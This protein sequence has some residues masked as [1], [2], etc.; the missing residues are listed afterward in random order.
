MHTYS[1]VLVQYYIME[2][3]KVRFNA[4]T[5]S[6]LYKELLETLKSPRRMSDV[7]VELEKFSE[8]KAL[9]KGAYSEI[10]NK[11]LNEGLRKL[12]LKWPNGNPIT[13]VYTSCSNDSEINI[14]ELARGIYQKS[15]FCYL[16][17]LYWNELIDQV[18]KT[19][20]IAHERPI[21]SVS[22]EPSI[23]FN[24]LALR[25]AFIKPPTQHRNVFVYNDN[26]V[27]YLARSY[28]GFAGVVLK[29]VQSHGKTII[30]WA[31]GLERTL[32]DCA[33][34]PENAGGISNVIEAFE[35]A[36]SRIDP[37][38]MV[39][40]YKDLKFKYPYWQR[41]GLI[42]D[43]LGN[44]DL[45]KVWEQSFGQPENKFFLMKEYRID[46]EY[47]EKW[48]VFSPKGLFK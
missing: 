48:K 38:L 17:A 18:P 5:R 46:W 26:H 47:N 14:L 41:I 23:E 2:N 21:T 37:I 16:P 28:S 12:K 30:V 10:K 6:A 9:S 11:I 15:Y 39:K 1:T 35:K 36:S 13:K 34:F 19:Y 25:D 22:S 8:D 32:I 33:T 4:I 20:F 27:V 45:S 24:D 40:L 42:F 3:K 43:Q 29:T 44:T 7:L 31:T